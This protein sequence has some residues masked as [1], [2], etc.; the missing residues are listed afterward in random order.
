[1]E[2]LIVSEKPFIINTDHRN[3]I[4]LMDSKTAVTD[5]S[6]QASDRI[7]RWI[8]AMGSYNYDI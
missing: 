2:H 5:R 6:K 3:L 7:Q 8:S 1:M 4:F